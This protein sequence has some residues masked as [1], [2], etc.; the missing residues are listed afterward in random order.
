MQKS[1][2][3]II[4]GLG[5]M[6]S[7]AAY[8]LAKRRQRVLGLDRF[9]P[10]HTFG[11]S[12]GETRIIREAY[13]EHP[14]YVPIVQRAYENWAELEH[15][16]GQKLFQQ[17]GGLM[18]GPPEGILVTGAQRSA[19]LHRLSHELLTAKE[20]CRRFPAFQ[21]SDEMVAVSEPRAGILF[22]ER[23]IAA[24][25]KLAQRYGATL[26]FDEPAIKWEREGEGVRVI[27]A[28]DEYVTQHLLIA[29]GAWINRLIPELALPLQVE[30]QVLLWFMPQI[31]PAYFSPQNCPIYIWEHTPNRFLYGFPDLGTGYARRGVKVGIHHEGESTDPDLVR[32]EVGADDIAAMRAI[33]RRIMPAIDT[34]PHASAVCLY[35]NTPDANFLID[36]HPSHPQVLLASICSGHGFKFSSA[37]GEILADLLLEGCSRFDLSLFQLARFKQ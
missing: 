4:L 16:A 32:R 29:A 17:T 33:L 28:K 37:V 26:Q 14:L 6:G 23:C 2:D 10:P 1:F 9:A 31:H 21:P 7:A 3:A 15:E 13:F 11:S 34:A 22:P 24:H 20:I 25:L 12:H 36:F 18:I 30:R 5:A 19:Q 27:T 8:H 35:T